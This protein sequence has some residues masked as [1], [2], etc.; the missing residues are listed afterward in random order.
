MQFVCEFKTAPPPLPEPEKKSAFSRNRFADAASRVNSLLPE[1]FDSRKQWPQCARI[2]SQ[3]SNQGNCA[4]CFAF[5]AL[6]VAASRL[7]IA[8]KTGFGLA[9]SVQQ[10]LSCSAH[11]QSSTCHQKDG[12]VERSYVDPS[13]ACNGGRPGSIFEFARDHGLMA[14]E[15]QDYAYGL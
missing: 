6:R 8:G 2:I 13:G 7:C 11:K 14:A 3:P 4:C 9:L 15:C 12:R 1:K 10:S 5:A